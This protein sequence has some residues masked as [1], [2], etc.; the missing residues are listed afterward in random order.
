MLIYS[1]DKTSAKLVGERNLLRE[2]LSDGHG[3][4]STQ[5]MQEFYH[6]LTRKLGADPVEASNL[7]VALRRFEVVVITPDIIGDA[8]KLHSGRQTSFWDFLIVCSAAFAN[9][10]TLYS[11]D[12]NHG[13][14]ILGVRV[15]NPFV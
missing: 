13:Q 6:N 15:M 14:T 3:V 12:M 7:V 2:I 5:V 10:S 11:E 4:V 8:M 9:C 1:A